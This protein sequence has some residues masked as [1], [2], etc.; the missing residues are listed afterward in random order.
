MTRKLFFDAIRP[1]LFAG[2]LS[3]PQVEGIDRILD[4]NDLRKLPVPQ[5]AYLLAT[6]YHETAKT[7]Q[8]I[9]EYGKGKGR[10]YGKKLKMS[11]KPYTTPDQIYYGRG[12][13]QLTWYE[14]YDKMGKLLGIDLLNHPAWALK[15]DIATKIIFEGMIRGT[16]T[17]KK[18]LDY[19]NPSKKDYKGARKIINGTDKDVLIAGY[20]EKFEKAL[21]AAG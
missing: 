11:G 9:E 3:T 18:L 21:I 8:A 7:M 12:F 1:S 20:A 17:G 4:E 2:K 13:V 5:L 16:F 19:L 14:N 15:T 10:P 6:T